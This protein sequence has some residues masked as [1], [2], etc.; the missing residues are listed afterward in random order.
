MHPGS[1]RELRTI[2]FVPRGNTIH[3]TTFPQT[4]ASRGGHVT[5]SEQPGPR[6]APEAAVTVKTPVLCIWTVLQGTLCE[7]GTSFDSVGW[8]T[9]TPRQAWP[10]GLSKF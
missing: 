4:C 7:W 2:V 10:H 6:Q 9:G 8:G 5:A 3:T 1:H